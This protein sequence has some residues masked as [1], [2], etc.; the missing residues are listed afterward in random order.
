[1][2]FCVVIIIL[3]KNSMR[4]KYIEF[5][6][7][8]KSSEIFFSVRVENRFSL[9]VYFFFLSLFC[10]LLKI[11]YN[12]PSSECHLSLHLAS[13]RR[14]AFVDICFCC[15]FGDDGISTL[16]IKTSTFFFFFPFSFDAT[17]CQ[18]LFDANAL[19]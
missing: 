10:S 9:T 7:V 13:S 5:T 18:R 12:L 1:M 8:A 3:C 17:S 16:Q 14:T 4:Q 15:V 2:P 19:E 6:V 11:R